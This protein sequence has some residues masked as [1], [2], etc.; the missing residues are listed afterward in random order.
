MEWSTDLYRVSLLQKF[1]SPKAEVSDLVREQLTTSRQKDDMTVALRQVMKLWRTID[2]PYDVFVNYTCLDW[3]NQQEVYQVLPEL[4]S[5][6][7]DLMLGDQVRRLLLNRYSDVYAIRKRIEHF[8]LSQAN[9]LKTRCNPTKLWWDSATLDVEGNQR[10]TS[11]ALEEDPDFVELVLS[12]LGDGENLQG[13]LRDY[14]ERT[15]LTN[16]Y[17]E[18]KDRV[19]SESTA[20]EIMA[21]AEVSSSGM[22]Q[23]VISCEP[24]TQGRLLDTRRRAKLSEK[25]AA[26]MGEAE[27]LG[28]FR[29]RMPRFSQLFFY[30]LTDEEGKRGIGQT[31]T[32]AGE[33]RRAA[34]AYIQS[35]IRLESSCGISDVWY[36]YVESNAH[37]FTHQGSPPVQLARSPSIHPCL[38]TEQMESVGRLFNWLKTHS[39]PRP[40]KIGKGARDGPAGPSSRAPTRLGGKIDAMDEGMAPRAK[41][42]ETD[43]N[44]VVTENSKQ[45]V[46]ASK[47]APLNTAEVVGSSEPERKERGAAKDEIHVEKTDKEQDAKGMNEVEAKSG[48]GSVVGAAGSF[49]EYGFDE[50]P[51]TAS[52]NEGL[53]SAERELLGQT[54]ASKKATGAELNSGA[55]A[56]GTSEGSET[57][58]AQR[59]GERKRAREEEMTD[60]KEC[61]LR[62]RPHGN[63]D[64]LEYRPAP[65]WP[66]KENKE[67]ALRELVRRRNERK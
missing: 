21:F 54:D 5:A 67:T 55:T 44:L 3:D 36:H 65:L 41:R 58:G 63:D 15:R 64:L 17:L 27:S 4:R 11:K 22:R 38:D 53:D 14:E 59:N 7:F 35:G 12:W 57:H 16:N 60:G 62:D 45:D 1:V 32:G 39:R 10:W 9:N 20:A 23:N 30:K 6:M 19:F 51:N 13:W 29:T 66:S 8:V 24:Q 18:E 25:S 37:L 47:A 56:G 34:E 52:F 42:S 31:R 50:W 46:S 33:A 2:T 61:Q 43:N 40:T 26:F 28:L 48:G 49:D